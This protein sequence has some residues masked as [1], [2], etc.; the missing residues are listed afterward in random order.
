MPCAVVCPLC[1]EPVRMFR[2]LPSEKVNIRVGNL[3]SH[4]GLAGRHLYYLRALRPLGSMK[5]AQTAE[6]VDELR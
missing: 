5:Y 4:L 3:K 1:N 6:I 2:Q